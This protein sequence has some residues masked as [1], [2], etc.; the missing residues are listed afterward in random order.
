MIIAQ[1]DW[2]LFW[3]GFVAG[4]AGFW[5]GYLHGRRADK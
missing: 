1:W 5:V 2:M 4:L 3:S